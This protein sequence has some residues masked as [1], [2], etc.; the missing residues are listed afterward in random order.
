MTRAHHCNIA[1][2]VLPLL[3]G[4]SLSAE[5][6]GQE[7]AEEA[8]LSSISGQVLTY[9]FQYSS[10]GGPLLGTYQF[11]VE[12][13]EVLLI[14]D[15]DTLRTKT[16]RAGMF[17]FQGIVAK[18]V[19]IY[20]KETGK[21][22]SYPFFGTFELMPG[23]NIL[24]VP[25]SWDNPSD[26]FDMYRL[27]THPFVTSEGDYWIYHYPTQMNYPPAD[28][29]IMEKMK[30]WRGVEFNKRKGLLYISADVHRSASDG[31]FLFAI[32]PDAE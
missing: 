1:R 22:L 13:N 31:G 28:Y 12:N 24:L 4:L 16:G 29:Y 11:P 18:Q 15:G 5:L 14:A 20:F 9:L 26:G 3:A 17:Y 30:D 8:N 21:S 27:F 6:Y 19:S 10:G 7:K 32:K 23:E 2:I 25:N